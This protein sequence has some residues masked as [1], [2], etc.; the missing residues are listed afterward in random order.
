MSPHDGIESLAPHASVGGAA[1]QRASM[2]VADV[3]SHYAPAVAA[4]LPMVSAMP[5]AA[6]SFAATAAAPTIHV[7]PAP[8]RTTPP[9]AQRFVVPLAIALDLLAAAAGL[10]LIAPLRY[11]WSD[12]AQTVAAPAGMAVVMLGTMLWAGAMSA[13]AAYRPHVLVSSSDQMTRVIPG[14]LVAWFG[15]QLTAFW[16]HVEVPFESRLVMGFAL[17]VSLVLV[18][19]LRMGLVRPAA[20]RA[21]AEICEGSVLFVGDGEDLPRLIS[22]FEADRQGERSVGVRALAGFSSADVA[23]AVEQHGCGVVVVGADAERLAPSFDAAFACLDAGAQVTIAFPSESGFECALPESFR[24]AHH[25][26]LRPTG[27]RVEAYFKRVMDIAGASVGLLLLSPV[28]VAI[29]ILVRATSPG[30]ALFAQ[31]RVGRRG[32]RFTMFKFRTMREGGDSRAYRDYMNGF[33]REG[34]HAE[35]TPNGCKIYKPLN[36]PRVTSVGAWLR[37]LSL[38]ELPQLWNVLRGEMSLVGPRP[39]LPWE[40]ELYE[41]WQRRRLD[42]LPGCTGLWQVRARSRVPFQEMVLLDLQYAHHATLWTDLGLILETF[43]VMM[44]GRGAS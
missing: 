23:R 17:P 7:L 27:S 14:A 26:R 11:G 42:V 32:R 19:M 29:G 6:T 35:T 4:E 33:I 21:Y 10:L 15:V 38:D 36:D 41:P 12:L 13:F 18:T 1:A 39:C 34:R 20:R 37:R 9:L 25:L 2:S 24:H 31:A 43:P 30:P 5:L 40:W 44:L 22:E 28:L 16:L 3:R 8:R